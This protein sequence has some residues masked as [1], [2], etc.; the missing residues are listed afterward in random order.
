MTHTPS[1][2]RIWIELELHYLGFVQ[3]FPDGIHPFLLS[4]IS[5]S[6]II[7]KEETMV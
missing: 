3:P 4:S 1:E 6:G 7:E 2:E 5:G